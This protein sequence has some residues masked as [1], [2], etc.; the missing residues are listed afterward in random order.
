M[1]LKFRGL[2][3]LGFVALLYLLGAL[4]DA[5]KALAALEEAGTVF[6]ELLPV[7][8]LIILLTALIDR[9]FDAKR[10]SAHLGDEGGWRGWAMA[11]GAG[12]I[13]HGPMYAW[14]PMLETLKAQ[15]LCNGYIATF[16]YARSVKVPL[17]PIMV[18]YFGLAFTLVLTFYILLASLL[19]GVVIEKLCRDC[20]DKNLKKI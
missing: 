8:P 2:K 18:D 5:P 14:Y 11:L 20:N 13:S 16:F 6:G 15:G 1:T 10:F 12:V 4:Y 19:Q 7:F 17:L 9:Y 3:L